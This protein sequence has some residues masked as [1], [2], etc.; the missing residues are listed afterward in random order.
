M[1]NNIL[2]RF[3]WYLAKR[4]DYSIV[5]KNGKHFHYT[6]IVNYMPDEITVFFT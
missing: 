2:Y 5:L 1:I 4:L 3:F 6:E